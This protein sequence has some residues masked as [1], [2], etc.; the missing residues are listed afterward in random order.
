MRLKRSAA[1]PRLAPLLAVPFLLLA[2]DGDGIDDAWYDRALPTSA[3][4][5]PGGGASLTILITD[6]P[7]E[8]LESL[9]VSIER[10][11]AH[12]PGGPFFEIL[13]GPVTFDLLEFR[14]RVFQLGRFDMP[15]GKY[16]QIRLYVTEAEATVD[17]ETHPV[18]IPSGKVRINRPFT[19]P[20]DA[21]AVMLLDFDAE[22]SLHLHVTGN[23]RYILRP[24]IKVKGMEFFTEEDCVSPESTAPADGETDVPV[25]TTVAVTFPADTELPDDPS[26]LIV[27]TDGDGNEVA[28]TTAAN[29][30][31]VTFT[32]DAD[33]D[34]DTTYTVT[35]A[36][37]ALEGY[38][39][40]PAS[41]FSFTT[42]P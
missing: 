27:L 25:D 32:P 6:A 20:E 12:R 1:L 9:V 22:E 28:G 3:T 35:V 19:L 15:P 18:R 2:C 37:H 5:S 23:D 21:I 34:P 40:C 24:V 39:Y 17:G 30:Q 4:R 7:V 38:G 41:T 8:G 26:G 42:A 29:G 14:D 31:T 11:E 33:L 36:I 13:H 16:T 10:V